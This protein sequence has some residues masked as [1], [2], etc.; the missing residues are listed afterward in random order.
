[1]PFPRRT[2][3]RAAARIQSGFPFRSA[4]RLSVVDVTALCDGEGCRLDGHNARARLV[5]AVRK[6]STTASGPTWTSEEAS[7]VRG[8]FCQELNTQML[9][10][11]AA[12]GEVLTMSLGH[13]ERALLDELAAKLN[14]PGFV[15]R[16]CGRL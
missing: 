13:R 15:S 3:T 10:A 1:M 8:V 7:T 12:H 9:V 6:S 4:T 2:Y 14:A 16:A 11:G 5:F